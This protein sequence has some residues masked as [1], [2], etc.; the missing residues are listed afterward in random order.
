MK[1]NL[2]TSIPLLFSLVTAVSVFAAQHIN[3]K[4]AFSFVQM[5]DTQ[6]GMGGYEHD[7]L[8]FNQAV[9][10][11]NEL[12]AD[13]VV[14]CGD[15]VNNPD[16]KSFGDFQAIRAKFTLPC[17]CAPGNHD[18][19]NVPTKASLATYRETIGKDYY[20]LEHKGYT[21][22]VANTQ[23]WKAPLEGES[24]KH[25]VW[26]QQT[27][28]EA[29][30]KNSPIFVVVHYPLFLKDIEEEEVYSNLPIEKRKEIF[31]LCKKNG[32]VAF[33]AGHTHRQISNEKEGILFVN[34]ETTSK[35]FDK[36]PMGF[37]H[38]NV[39]SKGELQNTFV[40]LDGFDAD[41]EK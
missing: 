2:K 1:V 12:Q 9:K 33:L 22:V 32:V 14:I 20:S 25:D 15:L 8:T 23:L 37:R 31:A 16:E 4:Q 13:F 39:G 41:P 30:A 27:L 26:F 11:I 6:L 19:G 18:V 35:N 34:G 7:V 38:W 36:R 28:E 3:E 5:C 17:Y 21:I 24:E 10:Q 29:K 40:K